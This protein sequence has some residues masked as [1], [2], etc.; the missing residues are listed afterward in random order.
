MPGFFAIQ[1]HQLL[2]GCRTAQLLLKGQQGLVE[3]P[4]VDTRQEAAEGGLRGRWILPLAIAPDPQ[5]SR[6][7]SRLGLSC[8]T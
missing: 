4:R 5:S 6:T 2:L 1:D 8:L 7:K 3:F